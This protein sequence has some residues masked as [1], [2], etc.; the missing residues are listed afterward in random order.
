MSFAS[1]DQGRGSGGLALGR[2]CFSTATRVPR[3]VNHHLRGEQDTVR[4]K[5]LGAAGV[6]HGPSPADKLARLSM[7]SI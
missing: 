2:G 7:R 6:R 1:A 5:S 3:V 4:R